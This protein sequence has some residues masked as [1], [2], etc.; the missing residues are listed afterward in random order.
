MNR[1]R[2]RSNAMRSNNYKSARVSSGIAASILLLA[3]G[4][5]LGQQ[6]N[7]TAKSTT[8][9]L[10]DGS[11]VPMWG[12]FCN[13]A[14]TAASCAV[15]KAPTG[16]TSW[17]A[18][19]AYALN[20]VIVDSNGNVE[21]VTTAGTSGT[22]IPAWTTTAGGTTTD[23]AGVLTHLVHS[24]SATW[25]PPAITVLSGTVSGAIHLTNKP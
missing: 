5:V 2:A 13:D 22:G 12:L 21:Q 15:L 3:S 11:S 16:L 25:A 20:A 24:Y 14:G 17:A 4:A 19:T 9:L 6:V 1:I 18:S 7:L 8:T 10:P 23:G